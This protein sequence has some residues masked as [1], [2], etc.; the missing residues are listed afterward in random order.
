MKIVVTWCLGNEGEFEDIFTVVL[1]SKNVPELRQFVS[2]LRYI[3]I[4][5]V[6]VV[7]FRR[8]SLVCLA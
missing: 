8:E 2:R 7:K 5:E 1:V 6:A 4:N 3:W